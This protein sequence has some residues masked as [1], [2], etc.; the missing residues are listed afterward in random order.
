M[1]SEQVEKV[2]KYKSMVN[3]M[4]PEMQNLTNLVKLKENEIVQLRE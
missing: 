1:F 3:R 2:K 4:K